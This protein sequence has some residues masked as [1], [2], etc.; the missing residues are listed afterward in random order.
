MYTCVGACGCAGVDVGAYVGL[1]PATAGRSRATGR[2][3]WR[4]LGP[5]GTSRSALAAGSLG[6]KQ[7][8]DINSDDTEVMVQ[9]LL[10]DLWV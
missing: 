1:V 8:R 6:L 5:G 7:G 10:Q 4:G 9:F 2:T 3:S